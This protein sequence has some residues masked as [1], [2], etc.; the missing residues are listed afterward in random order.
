MKH[1]T[2]SGSITQGKVA[3]MVLVDGDPVARI[4]DIRR[5]VTVIRGGTVYDAGALY[6]TLGVKPAL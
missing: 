1:D 6:R 4:S 3:D 2:E 5:V